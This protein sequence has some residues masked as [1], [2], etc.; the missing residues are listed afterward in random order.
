MSARRTPK[1]GPVDPMHIEVSIDATWGTTLF[2]GL[3]HK[4]L[5]PS[6]D[7]ERRFNR[8]ASEIIIVGGTKKP[9]NLLPAR[10][11]MLV[12]L[13]D[14]LIVGVD[15]YS[16]KGAAITEKKDVVEAMDGYHKYVAAREL[17]ASPEAKLGK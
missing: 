13:Y 11:P 16:L 15:G 2:R 7:H 6:L 1:E 4:F 12:E 14:E 3:V 10:H 8:A 17:F 9:K 5:P